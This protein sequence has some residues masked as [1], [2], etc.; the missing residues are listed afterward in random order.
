MRDWDSR[1][2]FERINANGDQSITADELC[3]F[4]TENFVAGASI[5]TCADMIAEYDSSGDGTL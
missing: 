1:N 5:E 3:N 2:L 4:M